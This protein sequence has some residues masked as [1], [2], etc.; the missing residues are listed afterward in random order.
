MTA[1]IG[2]LTRIRTTRPGSRRRSRRA[3][4]RRP[5]PRPDRRRSARRDGRRA[6]G[7]PRSLSTWTSRP[8]RMIATRSQVRSTSSMMCDDRK[9]VRPSSRASRTSPKNVCWTSGSR[10]DVGSSRMSRSGRCWSA[11]ISPTFCLLPLE[12]SLN[13][14]L[15]SRSSAL[16]E[17]ADVG[18]VHAAAQVR[19]VGRSS[20]HRSA[21]RTGRIRPADSRSVGGSHRIARGLDAEDLGAPRRRSD[22][23]EQDAHGRRLAGAVGPEEPEDLAL[24]DLEV[25]LGDAAMVP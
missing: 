5:Q 21:G 15:V 10:P 19:E 1:P 25:Q 6:G 2:P 14:R 9:I 3:G 22:Q 4:H 17:L 7:W 20:A 8:S 13:R 12:Y 16:D 18:L 24:G 11:T 23:V